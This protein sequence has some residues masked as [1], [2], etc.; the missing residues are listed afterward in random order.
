MKK[1]LLR[2]HVVTLIEPCLNVNI[3]NG[4][5]HII[6]EWE[7]NFISQPAQFYLALND[8]NFARIF[9]VDTF[10]R[11]LSHLDLFLLFFIAFEVPCEN[12]VW[13]QK[14][15]KKRRKRKCKFEVPFYFCIHRFTSNRAHRKKEMLPLDGFQKSHCN[16]ICV[17][18]IKFIQFWVRIG[19][20]KWIN[21]SD[22]VILS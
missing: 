2:W 3:P 10:I 5:N 4:D 9:V 13:I 6:V 19:W 17:K 11:M 16:N 20:I 8:I 14:K 18:F 7:K 21:C 12:V 22:D 15:K 1:C